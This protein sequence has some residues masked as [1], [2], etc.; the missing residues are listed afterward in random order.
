GGEARHNLV[1]WLRRPYV[2][3]G[4]SAHGLMNG[5]RYGNHYALE[6]W[7]G[8]LEAD[9]PCEAEREPERDATIAL[10]TV[11]LGLRL[12]AGLAAR[13]YTPRAW[14]AIERRYGAA[15][16]HAVATGRLERA[17]NGVRI[18]RAHAFVADDVIAWIEARAEDDR[19]RERVEAV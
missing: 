3:L 10:E 8:S 17:A 2:G 15:F 1:Y 19:R 11:M 9:T 18:P 4:P 5:E 7:A 16:A 6:R 13:D 14:A 12:T